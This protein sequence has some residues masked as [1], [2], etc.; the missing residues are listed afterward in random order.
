MADSFEDMGK[1]VLRQRQDV[2]RCKSQ[3]VLEEGSYSPPVPILGDSLDFDF[4]LNILRTPFAIR[5]RIGSVGL[6]NRKRNLPTAS[7]V[8]SKVVGCS[9]QVA[10]QAPEGELSL[11]VGQAERQ[12]LR[13]EL[14]L[15]RERAAVAGIVGRRKQIN[16]LA[17]LE[18]RLS[19]L[20]EDLR[21]PQS[22]RRQRMPVVGGRGRVKARKFREHVEMRG[23]RGREITGA[24]LAA[25]AAPRK[26][27]DFVA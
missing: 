12:L 17:D 11:V 3:L 22:M 27:D 26:E 25:S 8:G 23:Q 18:A 21:K 7:A 13:L 20:G 24:M 5:R 10:T 16:E 2:A 9:Q 19:D 6:I 15:Q 1:E 4:N 14:L